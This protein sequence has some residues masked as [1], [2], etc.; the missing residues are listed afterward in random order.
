MRPAG[1]GGQKVIAL[2]RSR[3]LKVGALL[4]IIAL[5]GCGKDNSQEVT[6][7]AATAANGTSGST[8]A[9]TPAI[10]APPVQQKQQEQAN[11]MAEAMRQRGQQGNK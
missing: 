3:A 4:A 5:A 7:P 9:G 11:Q 8:Q 6:G 1:R 10:S 2:K